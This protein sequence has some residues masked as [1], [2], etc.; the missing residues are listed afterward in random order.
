VNPAIFKK[1]IIGGVF[2]LPN[3]VHSYLP[4]LVQL[5]LPITL[6]LYPPGGVA[7]SPVD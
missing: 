3:M 5:Q 7:V 2:L 6:V 1:G 4:K